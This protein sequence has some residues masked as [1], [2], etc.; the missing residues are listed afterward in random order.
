MITK[1]S[2][3]IVSA[4]AVILFPVTVVMLAVTAAAE[5][6]APFMLPDWCAGWRVSLM[7]AAL[8]SV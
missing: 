2:F 7:G 1:P 3:R 6:A 4:I 8:V 5:A